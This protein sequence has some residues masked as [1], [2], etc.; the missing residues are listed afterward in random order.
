MALA[1]AIWTGS[2][3][4]TAWGSAMKSGSH[5]DKQPARK[6]SRSVR[7]GAEPDEI[8]DEEEKV[9][10]GRADVNLPALL[11]KDVPGG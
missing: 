6:R 4:V 9:L 5:D 3:L 8:I 2:L 10:A 11:T 7:K 1:N